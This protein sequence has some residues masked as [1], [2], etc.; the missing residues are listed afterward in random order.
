VQ[1][2][3]LAAAMLATEWGPLAVATDWALL[4]SL[5]GVCGAHMIITCLNVLITYQILQA[6]AH[7]LS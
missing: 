4:M 6:I 5:W 2:Q 3:V 7:G 1:G